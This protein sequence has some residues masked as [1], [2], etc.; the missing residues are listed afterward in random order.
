MKI[1][2]IADSG[3]PEQDTLFYQTEGLG[4]DVLVIGSS[5]FYPRVF[6]GNLRRQLRFVFADHRGFARPAD[7]NLP[8]DH[9]TLD[10][11]I[12]D[13]E[14]LRVK[15]GLEKFII[16]GHSGH[17]FM[18][19]EYAKKYAR[20]I[21][22]VV[23]IG[24]SP[25]YS[26]QTHR[27]TDLFF[28]EKASPERKRRYTEQMNRLPLLIEQHP[29]KRFVHF[30]LCSG[31]RNWFLHDF[32]AAPLWE[33]VYTNMPAI[34]YLWGTEF[35]KINIQ[36]ELERFDKPVLLTLGEHDYV[37]GPSSLWDQIIARHKNFTRKVFHHSGHY[38][39]YEEPQLFTRELTG[40][41]AD[42]EIIRSNA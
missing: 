5:V 31:A 4:T 13:L 42:H 20:H 26:P 2:E 23:L 41:L 7:E 9:Y 17:A 33:N 29:E 27:A 18:A 37:T 30:C 6:P 14:N 15:A 38:P 8:P 12:S 36:Q 25:D 16:V 19:L 1:K 39:M 34:D 40:W 11:I 10:L 35:S 24:V 22:G 3:F 28:E 32:D 21:L